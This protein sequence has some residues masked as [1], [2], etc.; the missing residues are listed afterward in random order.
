MSK[1]RVQ[2]G[3]VLVLVGSGAAIAAAYGLF[4]GSHTSVLKAEPGWQSAL[5]NGI[6]VGTILLV[7]GLAEGFVPT[8]AGY[9]IYGGLA[10]LAGGALFGLPL[11]G[12]PLAP[13][14][15]PALV[16]TAGGALVGLLVGWTLERTGS[17]PRPPSA[18]PGASNQP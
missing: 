1:L 8:L 10:G 6:V 15:L 13:G 16:G 7:G 14:L 12:S 5:F 11:L 3:R 17:S 2:A 18:P 9:A 4:R